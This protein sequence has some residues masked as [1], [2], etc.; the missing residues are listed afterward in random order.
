MPP[1]KGSSS[2]LGCLTI[3]RRPVAWETYN[4]SLKHTTLIECCLKQVFMNSCCVL[5]RKASHH[6]FY[7]EFTKP[8]HPYLFKKK[9]VDGDKNFLELFETKSFETKSSKKFQKKVPALDLTLR[10]LSLPTAAPRL[11]T[12]VNSS[13]SLQTPKS[14]TTSH[15]SCLTLLFWCNWRRDLQA[16]KRSA[17]A[18]IHIRHL[19]KTNW[20]CLFKRT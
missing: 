16:W 1:L 3:S 12:N 14:Q 18:R 2:T 11:P 9:W 15:V 5:V 10:S 19:R 6:E 4:L 17:S 13:F 20:R 8:I 7:N